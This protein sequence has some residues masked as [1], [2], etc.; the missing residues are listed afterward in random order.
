[1]LQL[2]DETKVPDAR[3]NEN[4][5]GRLAVA[6]LYTFADV[7]VTRSRPLGRIEDREKDVLWL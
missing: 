1:V 6:A 4:R 7:N 3:A 2:M 5:L